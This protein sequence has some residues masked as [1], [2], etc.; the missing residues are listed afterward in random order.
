[1]AHK[2]IKCGGRRGCNYFNLGFRF[3]LF[4]IFKSSKKIAFL[5]KFV[6][7]GNNLAYP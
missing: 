6:T 7:L 4:I 5:T 3:F 1:M 2:D